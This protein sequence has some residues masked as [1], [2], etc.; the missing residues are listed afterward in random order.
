MPAADYAG[1]P[2]RRVSPPWLRGRWITGDEYLM[3]V[4]IPNFHFH[5][6]MTYAILRHNGVPLGKIDF[7][8]GLSAR[9]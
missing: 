3:N 4:A 9:D 7:L 6:A 5:V 1:A 8:G 2:E